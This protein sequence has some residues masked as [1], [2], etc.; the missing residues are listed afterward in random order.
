MTDQCL[1]DVSRIVIRT[2]GLE[3]DNLKHKLHTEC[4]NRRVAVDVVDIL[5][6]VCKRCSD[7]IEYSLRDITQDGMCERHNTA[8]SSYHQ[9]ERV[10]SSSA[11]Q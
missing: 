11:L 5:S 3:Q 7:I 4:C 6:N 8:A 9:R 1:G 2:V 10:S